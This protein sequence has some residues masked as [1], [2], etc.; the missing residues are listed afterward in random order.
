[1]LGYVLKDAMSGE[2]ATA[3]RNAFAGKRY[4]GKGVRLPEGGRPRPAVAPLSDREKEVAL[5][6][7]D[8]LISKEIAE[9]LGITTNTVQVHRRNLMQKL[10]VHKETD[11][12]RMVV[13]EGALEWG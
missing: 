5:A 2:L 11:I 10:G 13:N 7:K 1:V 3:I 12:V 6:I 8:G 4:F 9:R